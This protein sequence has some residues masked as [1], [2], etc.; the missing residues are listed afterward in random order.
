MPISCNIIKNGMTYDLEQYG[1]ALI[2]HNIPPLPEKED[3]TFQIPG[4]AGK[5]RMGSQYKERTF[6]L[7][8]L[9][10]ADDATID[11]QSKVA[12]LAWL[13]DSIGGPEYWIFGDIPGKRFLGEYTGQMNLEKMIFDGRLTVPLVCY[14][15]FTET[16][17]DVANGWSY[18]EGYTYG[19]GLRFGDTYSKA[20]T[21][22]GTTFTIYHAGTAPLPP[23]IKI[24]G[25]FTNLSLNDGRGHVM[26][27]T[28]A[29]GVNDT[30]EIDCEEGTVYLNGTQN[31]YSQ[32]NAVFFSLPRGTTTFTFTASG[33]VN[34][35]VSFTPFRHR[36]LY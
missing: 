15:P 30:I 9:L 5:V 33:V 13:L 18:G 31:I 11:Y 23:K 19:M 10:M 20:V 32:T 2:K 21:V 7:E 22:S 36:Y 16:V 28:R 1:I 24:T 29:N 25:Q 27:I 17:T 12:E 6:D 3:Y 14:F 26:T 35:T 4:K 8:L 34:F